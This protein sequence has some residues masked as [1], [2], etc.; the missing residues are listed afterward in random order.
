MNISKNKPFILRRDVLVCL[1]LIITTFAVYWQVRNHDFIN[2]DDYFYVTENAHIQ[3]GL[4]RKG[5]VWAF[6]AFHAG[7]WIPLTWLSL[8]LD[9]ELYGLNAGGYHLTNLLFHIANTLL[10]FLVLNKMTRQLW[11]SAFV[12]ALFALHPLRVESV[13]WVTERKDVLSIFFWMLTIWAYAR[14]AERP[15]INRYLLA[16]F[17]FGLGLMAKPMIVTLPFVLLLLDYWP[18]DRFQPRRVDGESG[19]QTRMST[20]STYKMPPAFLMVWEKVPFFALAGGAGVVTLL[21]QHSVGAIGSL[22]VYPLEV[23]IA[24]ALLSYVRYI[25]KMI[26]PHHLVVFYLHPKESLTMWQAAGAGVLLVAVSIAIIWTAQRYRYLTFGWLWYL[27]TL[28]PVIGL[29]QSGFQAMADRFTYLPLIGLFVIIAWGVP[30]LLARYRYRRI[31][32][33]IVTG[34]LLPALMMSTWKQL[35]YWNNSTTL[36]KHALDVSP[37]HYYAHKMLGDLAEEEGNLEEAIAHYSQALEINPDYASAHN[38][39]GAILFKQAKL[40]EAINRF[41]QAL[42]IQPEDAIVHYNLGKVF[43]RQEKLAKAISHYNEAVRDDPKYFKAHNSLGMALARQGKFDEAIGHLSQALKIKPDY[44]SAHNN[45][46]A[47]LIR[48]GKLD[49]ATSHLAK[50][51][52]LRSDYAEAHD[53]LGALLARQGRLNEAISHF[54]QALEIKPEYASAHN[55]KGDSL[56][57]QGKLDEAVSHFSQALYLKPDFLEAHNNLGNLFFRQARF[58]EA[59]SQYH[60]VLELNPDLVYVRNNLGVALASEGRFEEAIAHFSLALQLKPDYVQA[61][62]NLQ[63][64]LQES[65]KPAEKV[66]AQANP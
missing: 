13:A 38:G 32:F 1:F 50:A 15:G 4:S 44:A 55:H 59:I 12:A 40:D 48:Q 21:A 47:L 8:M 63:K 17:A 64:V 2:L 56:A 3:T 62:N 36:W 23:R 35:R 66:R 58:A 45:L 61:R 30:D 11:R 54:S 19:P 26:W 46:G 5:I 16:L 18:L 34:A 28:V 27:G 52:E 9:F 25:G 65:G 20:K 22:D 51:L 39:I 10:L 7:L 53:N 29:V 31:A 37:K 14:Y 6:T 24:N 42:R 49:E 33:A 57:Q 43:A 41:Y 60:R